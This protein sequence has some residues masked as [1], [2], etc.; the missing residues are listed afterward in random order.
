MESKR[1]FLTRILGFLLVFA[2]VFFATTHLSHA[3]QSGTI[4]QVSGGQQPASGKAAVENQGYLETDEQKTIRECWMLYLS[5][6]A[7]A[8]TAGSSMLVAFAIIK[9]QSISVAMT[10][11]HRDLTEAFR[12]IGGKELDEFIKRTSDL[13]LNERWTDYFNAVGTL[14]VEKDAEFGAGGNP[15]TTREFVKASIRQG[16]RL[17]EENKRIQTGMRPLFLGTILLSGLSLLLIPVAKWVD[18]TAE[19]VAM[20]CAT[21]LVSI[22]LLISFL[23]ILNSFFK[24]S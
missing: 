1:P 6:L 23:M 8:V 2:S 21:G 11:I 17:A 12:D 4:E 14:A 20:W 5:A 10:T 24:K 16:H 9:I 18:N 19:L 15:K 22:V 7:V 3:G 13:F